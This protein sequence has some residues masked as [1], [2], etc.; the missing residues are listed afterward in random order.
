MESRHRPLILAMPVN[1]L[2]VARYLAA[3]EVDFIGV[4]MRSASSKPEHASAFI[5]QLREWIE[6][7]RFIG[8]FSGEAD[9]KSHYAE[10]DGF[11]VSESI[12]ADPSK[13]VF[14][15]SEASNQYSNSGFYK[16]CYSTED[17]KEKARSFMAS[18]TSDDPSLYRDFAGI[19]I[20]PGQES[21]T[22]MCDFDALD[23]WFDRYE[24][25]YRNN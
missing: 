12:Q 18:S 13:I 17:V 21:Q 7:P 20:N 22:G 14:Y 16:L 4:D 19:L 10:W 1:D 3:R 15:D 24:A 8:M 23:L 5:A 25:A 6:G 9:S 11:Y 2:T